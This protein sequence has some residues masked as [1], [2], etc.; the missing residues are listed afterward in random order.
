MPSKF[1]KQNISYFDYIPSQ[2]TNQERADFLK[3]NLG[4]NKIP[5]IG[6]REERERKRERG[7]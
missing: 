5:P 1:G 3:R 2:T 4:Q 6:D 7:G